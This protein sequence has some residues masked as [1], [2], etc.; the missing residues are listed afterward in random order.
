MQVLG[1]SHVIIGTLD[2]KGTAELFGNRLGLDFGETIDGRE[3]ESEEHRQPARSRLS[4][5]GIEV[6]APTDDS[7]P[8]AAYIDEQGGPC[9]YL[10][11]LEVAD[12]ET[13][14]N[15]LAGKGITPIA[16]PAYRDDEGYYMKECVYGPGAFGGI[17]F[18]LS[19]YH[20]PHPAERPPLRSSRSH[21]R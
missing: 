6:M 9:V 18:V 4:P 13:A 7:H 16:D 11:Q 20:A 21:D 10:V 8:L 17:M 1:I 12:L 19:E 5:A 15:E 3:F 2:L 14:K